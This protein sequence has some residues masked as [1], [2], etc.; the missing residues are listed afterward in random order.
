[1][2]DEIAITTAERTLR[3][4]ELMLSRPEGWTP[5]ELL[6]ELDL[7]RSALFALLRSLKDRGYIDQTGKRGRY[8][9]GPRLIAWRIV[10]VPGVQNLVSAFTQEI[11]A[12]R[13]N[14]SS[15]GGPVETLAL[16]I[17]TRRPEGE[18][19]WLVIAQVDGAAQ[20]RSTFN[21]G[22]VY[23]RMPAA[24][25]VLADSPTPQVANSGYSLADEGDTIELALPICRDGRNPEAALLVS[26]PA[27]RWTPAQFENTYLADLREAAARIS[28]RLGASFYAPYQPRPDGGLKSAKSLTEEEISAFLRGP[29]VASLA[30]VRPDGR[31]HV[32]PVWQEWDGQ[33]FLVLA[34]K[35]AQWGDYVLQNPHVSLTIDEPWIPLRRV[36]VQGCAQ[37]LAADPG[38]VER[39]LQR[40]SRRYLGHP[41]A[42]GLKQ[43]ILRAFSIQPETVRGWQGLAIREAVAQSDRD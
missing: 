12:S 38:E 4:I 18:P 32:I 3:L 6:I 21:T 20:V 30:C 16:V 9:P 13:M 29:Y 10:Q 36:V 5:Q 28:Y 33:R 37:A 25:Q 31:P 8:L 40:L 7:S 17:P 26:A 1:M 15:E 34:W 19:G 27:F 42:P 41:A 24:A 14:G 22:Q 2:S 35:G 39:L 11:E 43:Q 23:S